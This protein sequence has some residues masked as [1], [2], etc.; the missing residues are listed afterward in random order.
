MPTALH[1]SAG[2]CIPS[3]ST[4]HG[5]G[6]Q[7]AHGWGVLFNVCHSFS[8][9]LGRCLGDGRFHLES[10]MIA[11]PGIPAY[12]YAQPAGTALVPTA[13]GTPLSPACQG[14]VLPTIHPVSTPN[15]RTEPQAGEG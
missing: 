7:Q 15:L 14:P 2:T 6:N 4:H 10:I 13:G 9:S 5:L 11:N 3:I 8:F 12:R 1:P